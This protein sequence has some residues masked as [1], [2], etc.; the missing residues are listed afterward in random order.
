MDKLRQLLEDMRSDDY[1]RFKYGKRVEAAIKALDEQQA[2]DAAAIEARLQEVIALVRG[3]K[4]GSPAKAGS[5]RRQAP[6]KAAGPAA[7]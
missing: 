6:K 1:V 2:L 5:K 3:E 7:P 4:G